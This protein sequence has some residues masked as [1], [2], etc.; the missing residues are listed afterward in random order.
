MHANEFRHDNPFIQHNQQ[1]SGYRVI[2]HHPGPGSSLAGFFPGLK[3]F[4][5]FCPEAGGVALA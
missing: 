2:H 5:A 3:S 4:E 1:L